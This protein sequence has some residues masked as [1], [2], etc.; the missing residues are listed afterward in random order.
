MKIRGGRRWEGDEERGGMRES[1]IS[2]A[3]EKKQCLLLGG[4]C[5][6]ACLTGMTEQMEKDKC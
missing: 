4:A 3:V 1:Q 6:A 5:L 2:V